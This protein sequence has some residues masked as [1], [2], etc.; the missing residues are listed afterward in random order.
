MYAP[1]V[2][3][4]LAENQT[5]SLN[6]SHNALRKERN[7]GSILRFADLHHLSQNLVVS[8]EQVGFTIKISEEFALNHQ[9]CFYLV[10]S[11]SVGLISIFVSRKVLMKPVA[12]ALPTH[13]MICFR[14]QK[15]ITTKLTRKMMKQT[16]LSLKM[17]AFLAKKSAHLLVDCFLC[18]NM[19]GMN[20]DCQPLEV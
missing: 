7:L 18:A 13:N 20:I 15:S 5:V 4:P 12:T 16:S 17:I 3:Y 11:L 2:Q 10:L 1:N 19:V 8:Q 9:S 14:L 6:Y